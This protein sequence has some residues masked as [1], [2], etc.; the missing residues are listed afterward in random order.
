MIAAFDVML[1]KSA[2]EARRAK[3][4]HERLCLLGGE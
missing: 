2:T 3:N 4:E 1:A